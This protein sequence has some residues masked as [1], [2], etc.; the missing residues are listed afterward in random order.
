MKFSEKIS[1][2]VISFKLQVIF[3]KLI[4][5]YLK[6][7]KLNTFIQSLSYFVA[8]EADGFPSLNVNLSQRKKRLFI[9]CF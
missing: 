8:G 1:L 9:A 3:I 5:K 4:S 7:P 6:N 2:N